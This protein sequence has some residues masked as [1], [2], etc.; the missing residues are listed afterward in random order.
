MKTKQCEFP[1]L[2]QGSQSVGEYLQ[3][4]NHLSRYSQYDVA[5]EERKMDR[6][7][8]GL[9]P[10]LHCAL[11]VFY[12]P[13]FQALVNKA[14][15]AEREHKLIPDNRPANNDHKRK[16]E[17]RKEVQ[18]VQKARTWQHTQVDYKPNWQQNV[19]KTTTQVKNVVTNP[20]H[21]ESVS[22]IILASVVGRTDI[23]PDSAPRTTR[24]RP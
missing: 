12:F 4:F 16:F 5:T 21:E 18:P 10:Q 7:L 6:F 22:A 23:M 8:G 19:N 9:N 1:A 13:D 14:F 11:S 3:K 17:P 24:R 20:M 2:L 15:I